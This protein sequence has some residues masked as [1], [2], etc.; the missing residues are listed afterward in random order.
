MTTL[1]MA[2]RAAWAFVAAA[3]ALAPLAQGSGVYKWRDAQGNL[4]FSDQ[5]P[6]EAQARG[7]VDKVALKGA[8]GNFNVQTKT[9]IR[10]PKPGASASLSLERFTVRLGAVGRAFT[11]GRAF[12]GRN[13]EKAT[14]MQ[15]DEGIVD[16]K[17]KVAQNAVAERFRNAG[18]R[19]V[20]ADSGDGALPGDFNLEADLVDLKIDACS[21]IAAGGAGSGS[22]AYLKMRW[23]L[24]GLDGGE[25]YAGTS[26][27]A[28]DGWYNGTQVRDSVRKALDQ[29]TDNL[30]GEAAFADRLTGS[31]SVAASVPAGVATQ[32]AVRYGDAGTTFRG[33]SEELLRTALTVRTT[34]GHGSGVVI[35]AA[36][37]A[38]TNAHVVGEDDDVQVV[39][40]TKQVAAHVVGR[41][42]RNDVA[43]LRFSAD[44]VKGASLARSA[45]RPGDPL[46]VVGTPLSLQ[47]SH[48]VTEGILSAVR[49]Q[50]GVPFYQTDATV[51][52]GNSGG[53][54]FD[55]AGEL[56]AISVSR[57]VGAQ[58]NSLNVNYLIPI[59]RALDAVGVT[60]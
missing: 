25:L 48:S 26:E 45:P 35:D 16:S 59:G 38:L 49:S 8:Y 32:V 30:L 6:A 23:A 13:C 40:D 4:H 58:G 28:Y 19:L 43:L 24:K 1:G 21:S 34:R 11:V 2:R 18:Y 57:L 51:N 20:V 10:N 22:R 39:V 27:G 44:D 33:R 54:V 46:Y 17:G 29:A 56:V 42:R 52:P 47:L 3:C 53:P 41:D 60:H 15:W 36:G 12:S 9:P 50:D 5:P 37:Y 7:S 31:R 55:E 14:D